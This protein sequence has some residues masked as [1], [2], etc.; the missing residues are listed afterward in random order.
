MVTTPQCGPQR[1]AKCKYE[2]VSLL[3]RSRRCALVHLAPY[4][5]LAC[6]QGGVSKQTRL[7]AI[8][9]G[10]RTLT[11][12]DP[13]YPSS[14]KMAAFASTKSAQAAFAQTKGAPLLPSRV[15]ARSTALSCN[16]CFLPAA[17]KQLQKSARAVSI[18]RYEVAE[19]PLASNQF[20]NQA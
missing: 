6:T 5:R 8:T 3:L 19:G 15:S 13:S 9:R 11:T 10:E 16:A 12:A 20:I 18:N 14:F 7:R 2:Q 1:R 17:A 4:V